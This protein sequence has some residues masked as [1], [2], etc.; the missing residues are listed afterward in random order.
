MLQIVRFRRL[1][2]TNYAIFASMHREITIGV[3]SNYLTDLQL[4]KSHTPV[5]V[6]IDSTVNYQML[7]SEPLPN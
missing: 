3:L 2:K 1:R 4:Q 5:E 7:Y 6:V